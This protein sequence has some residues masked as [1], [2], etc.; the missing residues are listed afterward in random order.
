MKHM[1]SATPVV[2]KRSSVVL[3][4]Y[5]SKTKKIL[6]EKQYTPR[7][8]RHD[9]AMFIFNQM[10]VQEDLVDIELQ[11]TEGEK[12]TLALNNVNVKQGDG[13]FVILRDGKLEVAQ[14]TDN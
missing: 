13:T 14:K 5:A 7:G 6:F 10:N 2:K 1:Q 11:E 4:I 3:K 8:L 9:I 12:K